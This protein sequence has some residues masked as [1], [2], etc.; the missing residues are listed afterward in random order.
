M[1][2]ASI[3]V[4][5]RAAKPENPSRPVRTLVPTASSSRSTGSFSSPSTRSRTR[6]SAVGF[7][8]S[9]GMAVPTELSA[10]TF[11]CQRSKLAGTIRGTYFVIKNEY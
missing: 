11:A 8:L 4:P 3:G 9:D 5:I 10:F 6:A 1:T 2:G 7:K